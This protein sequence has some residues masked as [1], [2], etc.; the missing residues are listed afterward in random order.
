MEKIHVLLRLTFVAVS[1]AVARQKLKQPEHEF[2]LASNTENE[3][4]RKKS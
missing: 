4:F 1:Y 2:D 3:N